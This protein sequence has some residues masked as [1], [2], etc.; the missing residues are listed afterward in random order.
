M[1][2]STQFETTINGYSILLT[3]YHKNTCILR[4]E[5][6]CFYTD[7]NKKECL[8]LLQHKLTQSCMNNVPLELF[9]DESIQNGSSMALS[10]ANGAFLYAHTIMPTNGQEVTTNN[11]YLLRPEELLQ[12]Y[13]ELHQLLNTVRDT[14]K[15]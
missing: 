2:L 4:S 15:D 9:S 3:V 8:D 6:K 10:F 7:S 1:K 12:F 14:K 5:Y 11:I 13:C